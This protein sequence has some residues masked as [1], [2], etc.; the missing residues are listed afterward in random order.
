MTSEFFCKFTTK[1]YFMLPLNRQYLVC[2]RTPLCIHLQVFQII[3]FGLNRQEEVENKMPQGISPLLPLCHQFTE[4]KVLVGKVTHTPRVTVTRHQ[5]DV[6]SL[7]L[8]GLETFKVEVKCSALPHRS[9][10]PH[11]TKPWGWLFTL[12]DFKATLIYTFCNQ[13]QN[14]QKTKEKN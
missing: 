4:H 11:F 8:Q 3:F 1:N 5:L 9:V 12:S 14:K 13:K 10:Q 2:L 7:N 6:L